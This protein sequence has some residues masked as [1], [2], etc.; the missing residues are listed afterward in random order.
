MARTKLVRIHRHSSRT[1]TVSGAT[2]TQKASI[3]VRK[4]NICQHQFARLGGRIS[5]AA[6]HPEISALGFGKAFEKRIFR[7]G[8]FCPSLRAVGFATLHNHLAKTQP[9]S[10][11]KNTGPKTSPTHSAINPSF[12]SDPPNCQG[13]LCT[14]HRDTTPNRTDTKTGHPRYARPGKT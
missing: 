13:T 9:A 10:A 5:L 8:H 14:H 1:R 2:I 6:K 7:F 12:I 11:T 4:S 3:S